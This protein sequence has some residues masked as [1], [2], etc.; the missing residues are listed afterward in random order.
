MWRGLALLAA[1]ELGVAVKRGAAIAVVNAVAVLC[2]LAALGFALAAVHGVL[3]EWYGANAASLI[4][5]G[6]FFLLALLVWSAAALMRRR[7]RDRR[8][9]A[10]ALALTAPVAAP[11]AIRALTSRTGLGAGLA[12]GLAALFAVLSQKRDRPEE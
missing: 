9:V 11:A 4:L 3:G 2:L 6:A 12:L 5:A 10:T 7:A 1:G 8:A